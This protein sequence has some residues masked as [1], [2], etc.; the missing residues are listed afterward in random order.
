MNYYHNNQR[1]NS[2]V[3]W[4]PTLKEISLSSFRPPIPVISLSKEKKQLEENIVDEYRPLIRVPKTDFVY[5]DSEKAMDIMDGKADKDFL[6]DIHEKIDHIARNIGYP[7]FLRSESTSAKHYWKDSC[8]VE[9]KEDIISHFLEVLEFTY[10][11]ADAHAFFFAVREMI[12]TTPLYT[13]FS[14]DMPIAKECRLFIKDGEVLCLHPYWPTEAFDNQRNITS[15]GIAGL[16]NFSEA[17]ETELKAQAKVIAEHFPGY[18]SVDFLQDKDGNW[19]AIDM[20]LGGWSYH[21]KGCPT[22]ESLYS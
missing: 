12:P 4:Y 1:L 21:W 9:R 20:A 15:E 19:W 13:T 5:V 17:E 7:I 16:Q 14:G 2:M 6:L 22:I 3:F 11:V 18:W 10:T 8:F